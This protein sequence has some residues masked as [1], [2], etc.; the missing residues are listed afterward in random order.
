MPEPLA[1]RMGRGYANIL[2]SVFRF[3]FYI[4]ERYNFILQ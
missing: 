4:Y 3:D 2:N 1:A